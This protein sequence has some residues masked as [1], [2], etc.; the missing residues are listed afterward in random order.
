[1]KPVDTDKDAAQPM[2]AVAANNDA[3]AIAADIDARCS[4]L[5]DRDGRRGGIDR[6]QMT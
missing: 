5:L 3:S 6:M 1:M 2:R 4:R